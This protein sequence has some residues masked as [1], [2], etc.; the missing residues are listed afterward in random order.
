MTISID[1]EIIKDMPVVTYSGKIHLI[2]KP[3]QVQSAIAVL[4]RS[5]IVGFDTESRPAFRKGVHN[6]IALLQLATENEAFLFRLCKI[7]MPDELTAFLEDPSIQKVGLST[8]DDFLQLHSLCNAMPQGFIELQKVVQE[9][10]ITDLGLQKIYAI[11]F[12]ERI[13]KSRQLSNWAAE[14]LTP[15]QQN[16][17]AID[18]WACLRIYEH[19]RSGN[20]VPEESPYRHDEASSTD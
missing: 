9:F 16:Y 13:N 3:Q 1:K 8:H 15:S 6:K 4:R 2:D 10:H 12:G 11:L 20:F 14:S 19:L 7:G 18:A 17:A 5:D